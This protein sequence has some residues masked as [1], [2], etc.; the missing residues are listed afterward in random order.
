MD[1]P[2]FVMDSAD[3]FKDER[4]M[5]IVELQQTESIKSYLDA[6]EDL[7]SD[8]MQIIILYL[9]SSY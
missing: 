1:W 7:K 2:E 3:R 4:G 8:V 5:N 6:F 9:R